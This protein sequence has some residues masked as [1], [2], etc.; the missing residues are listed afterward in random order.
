MFGKVLL[1]G[2]GDFLKDYVC[3]CVLFGVVVE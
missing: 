3:V 2:S 1:F